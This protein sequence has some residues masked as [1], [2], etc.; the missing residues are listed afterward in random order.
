MRRDFAFINNLIIPYEL[1]E[2]FIYESLS[3][4]VEVRNYKDI[5]A[6]GDLKVFLVLEKKGFKIAVIRY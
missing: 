5:I 1:Q 3:R 2:R 4:Y 6:C